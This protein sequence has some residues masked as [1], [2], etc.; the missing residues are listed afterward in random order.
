MTEIYRSLDAS[1]FS[2]PM[3]GARALVDMLI[4][5]KVGDTGTFKE[6]LSGLVAQGYLSGKTKKS[7]SRCWMRVV[8]Q[9]IGAIKHL[10][11]R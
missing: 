4:V 5:D 3:M 7:L 6:K 10:S 9:P 2:L 1:N 8:P 11:E